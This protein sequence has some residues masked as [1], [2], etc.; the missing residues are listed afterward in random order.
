MIRTVLNFAFTL[1]ILTVT[2]CANFASLLATPTPAPTSRATATLQPSATATQTTSP[3][4]EARILRIWLPPRFDPQ[5]DSDASKLLAQRLSDFQASHSG[6]KIEVRIKSET[7]NASLINSLTITHDAAPS[8]LPDLIALPHR[9]LETAALNGLLH[10]MDGLSTLLDDPSWYPYARQLGH[11]Q[12][13]GYGLPFA[14]NVLVFHH[15]PDLKANNW[16]E[17]LA[18][19]ESLIFPGGDLQSLFL[20]SLYVS[21]GGSLTDD[22]GQPTLEEAPLTQTLTLLQDGVE[23][24]LFSPSLLN[25]KADDQ[26]LQAYRTGLGGMVITWSANLKTDMYPIPEVTSPHTFA[27]GWVWALAGSS[28]ENQQLAVE[29]AEYLLD[30]G[31]ANEWIAATGFLP[32]RLSQDPNE[33]RILAS[34]QA[35]PTED[36]LAVLG[37]IMNQALIRLIEGEQVD[38]IVRSVLEQVQ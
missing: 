3:L 26:S 25:Y 1:I 23:S 22:Q 13:I 9:D 4:D 11:V 29:L 33:D 35:I 21:A 34:A 18:S 2:G 32:G 17:I 27:D 36:V 5:T 31:F 12:N 6:L 38:V 8:A 10:P 20:L 28:T 24:N 15:R 19:K 30:D 7:G 16:D 14:G 37:P